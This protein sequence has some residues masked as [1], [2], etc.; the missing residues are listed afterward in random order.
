MSG[1]LVGVDGSYHSRAA[2]G[3]A[4]REAAQHHCPLTVM[5]VHQEAPRPATGIYWGIHNY[6]ET[7][8][9]A[10][11]TRKA[12]AQLVDEVAH[13]TGEKPLE[14]TLN[15]T[16]GDVAAELIGASRD[17][18]MVVVGSR[19]GGGFAGLLMGS[20]SSKVAHHAKCPVVV[21]RGT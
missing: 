2:L 17:A 6:A 16:M 15:V 7:S 1:I 5:A 8:F 4:V 13:E 21:I 3:W 12:V 11:T 20:V 10:E 19:G 9:D 14:V 18:D